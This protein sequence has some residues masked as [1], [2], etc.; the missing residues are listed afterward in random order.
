[1]M[2]T[3]P[4][5]PLMVAREFYRDALRE[6]FQHTRLFAGQ[7]HR[8]AEGVVDTPE[9]A[10]ILRESKQGT[11]DAARRVGEMAVV[12]LDTASEQPGPWWRDLSNYERGHFLQAAT[13]DAGPPTNRP[14]RGVSALCMTFNWQMPELLKRLNSGVLITDE[15]RRPMTL[16]FARGSQG[17]VSVVEVG[18][19]VEKVFRATNGLRPLNQI[20][21]TAGL[22][23]PETQQILQALSGI[24]AVILA[25]S[26]EQ[27][28]DA[29]RAKQ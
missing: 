24:G 27:M 3:L 13:T 9:F 8:L 14:R 10:A 2:A 12:H 11:L 19:Q 29:I 17:K 1:M 7:T 23:M 26:A 16:L 4:Q 18:A 5:D 15:L 21:A 22:S 20:A 6:S 28:M 25:Q